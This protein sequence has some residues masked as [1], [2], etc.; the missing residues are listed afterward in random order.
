V[1]RGGRSQLKKERERATNE[2]ERRSPRRVGQKRVLWERED[3]RDRYE[4]PLA[5]GA[6]GQGGAAQTKKKTFFQLKGLESSK[7]GKE[8]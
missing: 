8:T 6:D 2:E 5:K 3:S 1:K 4:A 7:T